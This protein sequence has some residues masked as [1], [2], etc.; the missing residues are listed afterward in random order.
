MH[1]YANFLKSM[2]SKSNNAD[3]PKL[4]NLDILTSFSIWSQMDRIE[5]RC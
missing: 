1:I 4:E 5:L 2:F 3:F